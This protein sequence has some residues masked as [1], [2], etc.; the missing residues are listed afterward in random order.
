MTT[1]SE[2]TNIC[3][4]QLD[5]R[6]IHLKTGGKDV[7]YKYSYETHKWIEIPKLDAKDLVFHTDIMLFPDVENLM[8]SADAK[9]LMRFANANGV[10][11]GHY[12]GERVMNEMYD[13]LFDGN[14]SDELDRDFTVIGFT[15]GVYDLKQNKFRSGIPEDRISMCTGY[16]YLEQTSD[17]IC[18]DISNF[19]EKIQPDQEMRNYLMRSLGKLLSKKDSIKNY[20]WS[21]PLFNGAS[22]LLHLLRATLGDYYCNNTI[23]SSE[24]YRAMVSDC[25]VNEKIFSRPRGCLTTSIYLWCDGQPRFAPVKEQYRVIPFL[26]HNA[27]ICLDLSDEMKASFMSRLIHWHNYT[28]YDHRMCPNAIKDATRLSHGKNTA[29]ETAKETLSVNEP[30]D[31]RQS[32]KK[33]VVD[34]YALP[35]LVDVHGGL[36][37]KNDAEFAV[38][39]FE[40]TN[41]VA[42]V[43]RVYISCISDVFVL[44][45]GKLSNRRFKNGIYIEVPTDIKEINKVRCHMLTNTNEKIMIHISSAFY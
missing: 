43:K 2:I 15:N 22:K 7:W 4:K 44:V 10:N 14:F 12:F 1:V 28:L 41:P 37:I 11:V 40:E 39:L 3:K 18:A 33:V 21:G 19:L 13:T 35:N 45:D 16:P 5:A 29:D 26:Q 20:V 34:P 25:C 27:N 38:L 24:K 36:S 32:S 8:L 9:K 42:N 31:I 30:K 6:R 23:Y 17:H